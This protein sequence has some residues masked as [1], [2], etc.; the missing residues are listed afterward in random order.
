MAVFTSS[1]F[2]LRRKMITEALRNAGA[3]SPES[4][5]AMSDTGLEN[6][7]L[8]PEFTARLAD[9]DVIRRTPDGRFYVHGRE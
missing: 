5:R 1:V 9:M 8:F 3:V 6:P 7:D 2:A 4:A